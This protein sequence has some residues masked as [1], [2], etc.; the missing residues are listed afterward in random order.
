MGNPKKN[1]D[2]NDILVSNCTAVG[3]QLLSIKHTPLNTAIKVTMGLHSLHL[4]MITEC[5]KYIKYQEYQ[6]Y[7][8]CQEYQEYHKQVCM[9]NHRCVLTFTRAT[10]PMYSSFKPFY[11]WVMDGRTDRRVS[12]KNMLSPRDS[13]NGSTL[14][15]SCA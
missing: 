3:F 7:Q 6:E 9:T 1:N 15:L 14:R 2:I 11:K 12:G 5:Q 10:T 4:K 8:V 13:L